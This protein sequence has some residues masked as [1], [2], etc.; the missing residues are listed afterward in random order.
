MHVEIWLCTVHA[1]V[2]WIGVW[3]FL[4][5]VQVSAR[6]CY[7]GEKPSVSF[8]LGQREEVESETISS[9]LSICESAA[10]GVALMISESTVTQFSS[11]I[12]VSAASQSRCWIVLPAAS[13]SHCWIVLPATSQFSL[14]N[15]VVRSKLVFAIELCYPQW[16]SFWCQILVSAAN[17]CSL[18]N[19]I[20]RNESAFLAE[21]CCP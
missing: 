3:L 16:I 21:L 19:Y 8:T 10:I 12:S 11:T 7:K 1:F 17:Q 4:L 14:P 9:L 20:V 13:Q 6:K 18:P 5:C 2:I 15:C